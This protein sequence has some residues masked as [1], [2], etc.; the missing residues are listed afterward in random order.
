MSGDFL[1]TLL[2]LCGDEGGIK[3]DDNKE[4]KPSSTGEGAAPTAPVVDDTPHVIEHIMEE[5]TKQVETPTL[6]D[7]TPFNAN[8]LLLIH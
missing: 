8:R 5:E 4:A 1:K 6:R 2:T 3:A 7:A